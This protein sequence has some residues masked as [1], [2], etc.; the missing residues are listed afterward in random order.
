MTAP[1]VCQS[2]PPSR[3]LDPE[4]GIALRAPAMTDIPAVVDAVHE[5]L[6]ALKAFMVWAHLENTVDSQYAR[7]TGVIADFWR[8]QD[9]NFNV[10]TADG[11]RFLGCVGLHRRAMNA[12]ALEVG[13]WVRTSAAGR[14]ICT[15]ATRA[16]AVLAFEHFG[17]RRLQCGFD[18]A[19][20]ASARVARKVGFTVEGDLRDYGPAG[21]D[22]MRADG[23]GCAG[24][25]RM[26]ALSADDARAQ[27]WYAAT[28]DRLV[29][30]DWLGAPL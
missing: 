22:A 13:Y 25:N 4:G 2:R 3:V 9:Y 28:R 18:V 27:P 30:E 6:D 23:F 21:T 19:N 5:S 26:T 17:C 15:R 10:F 24:I 16:I 1:R 8:G 11:Q 14:G 20:V 7:M 29:V 12:R